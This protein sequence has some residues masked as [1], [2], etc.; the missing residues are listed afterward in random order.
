MS[1][2]KK[3]Q[4]HQEFT[5][6]RPIQYLIVSLINSFPFSPD[7]KAKG[8]GMPVPYIDSQI[9]SG[10]DP[11]SVWGFRILSFAMTEDF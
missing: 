11:E 9:K 6:I 5:R 2:Y 3:Q 4:S 1:Q 10:N 8:T 7:N